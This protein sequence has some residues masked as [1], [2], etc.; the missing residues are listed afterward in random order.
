MTRAW[1]VFWLAAALLLA[2]DRDSKV[3]ELFRPF[4]APGSPGCAVGVLEK[5]EIALA[6][7]Y[8]L[9]DLDHKLPLT[10]ASRFYMASVSKQFT[11]MAALLAGHEDK[12]SLDEDVRKYVP[13]LPAY[14]SGITLRR[15]LDHTAGLRDY[16]GLWSLKGFS[17]ESVLRAGPTLSLVARQKALDFEPGSA[18]N[19]SNTGYFLMSVVIERATGKT[20]A[21][22]AREKI[23]T[24]LGMTATRFQDDH[25][26]PV[27]DRAHGYRQTPDGWRTADV[28][29]DIVGSGGLYS[30]IQDML[31]WARNF[32]QPVVG[33]AV[34]ERLQT[35]GHLTSGAGT[36]G[37]Y[38]LGITRQQRG[39]VTVVSHSGGATGYSTHFL[40]VPEKSLA[41]VTLCNG[42]QSA[43]R[44]AE[45]AAEVY[46]GMALPRVV[47]AGAPK[48]ERPPEPQPVSAADRKAIMGHYWSGELEEMW[49]ILEEGELLKVQSTGGET[50]LIKL[51]GGAYRAGPAVLH[52]KRSGEAR[53]SSFTIEMGRTKNIEFDRR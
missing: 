42:T 14:A 20:L 52:L 23:F 37:G 10:P 36:P 16:L 28:N 8:G 26:R 5:G 39:G 22:Y 15:M 21:A 33:A 11:S 32:E 47:A 49:H 3:D 31:K 19:Y 50:T 34:L 18:Y 6:R 2:S 27:P 45:S 51:S 12:L 7:G 38:A 53:V 48:P 1:F 25:S 41:V 9:A 24:P 46:L 13:E 29:F 4:A 40:R 43:A 30:N 44:L 35:P 17:N